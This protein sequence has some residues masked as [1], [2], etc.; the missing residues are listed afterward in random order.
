MLNSAVFNFAG[1]NQ[2]LR[3]IYHK[4]DLAVQGWY[5][6]K[7]LNIY[8]LDNFEPGANKQTIFFPRAR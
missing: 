8:F 1:K 7:E 2:I 4:L 3:F 5:Q 6:M